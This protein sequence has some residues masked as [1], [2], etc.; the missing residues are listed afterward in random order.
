[1]PQV[2]DATGNNRLQP[3]Q[4]AQRQ[5]QDLSRTH[6]TRSGGVQRCSAIAC[7]PRALSLCNTIV[8][9]ATESSRSSPLND[10]LQRAVWQSLL[11]DMRANARGRA[12]SLWVQ[13]AMVGAL[14]RRWVVEVQRGD[15]VAQRYSVRAITII[16][17]R[18][19]V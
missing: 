15:V 12:R 4:V 16:T 1:M 19:V 8:L 3:L 13:P 9:G 5:I 14:P 11:D 7:Q 18:R 6:C 10:R 17:A 2:F